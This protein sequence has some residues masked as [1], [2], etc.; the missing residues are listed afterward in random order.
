[1]RMIRTSYFVCN[2]V[3]PRCGANPA[4]AQTAAVQTSIAPAGPC[5]RNVQAAR[6]A[7]PAHPARAFRPRIPLVHPARASRSHNPPPQRARAVRQSLGG[8][9]A[10]AEMPRR[11]PERTPEAHYPRMRTGSC[12]RPM[13]AARARAPC[14]H[15]KHAIAC[16][17]PKHE[18]DTRT[19]NAHPKRA[20]KKPA[21]LPCAG[22]CF[23][24]LMVGATGVEPVTYAL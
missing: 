15:P 19:R 22:F 4:L 16:P 8:T 21:T 1:M 3:T 14:P 12:T 6:A 17:E 7:S 18:P 23:G 24:L 5:R 9:Q 2:I 11:P 13:H 10:S 20:N